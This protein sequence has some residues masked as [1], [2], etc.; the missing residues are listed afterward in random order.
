MYSNGIVQRKFALLDEYLI[1]LQNHLADVDF[2]QFK[3]DW[4]LRCAAERALQVIAEIVIDVTQRTL[5]LANAGPSASAAEALHKAE[6]LNI[7]RD[8][9]L[10][11]PI[12]RFRN[13]VVHEYERIDP[14]VLYDICQNHLERV[15]GFREEIERP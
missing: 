15:R 13:L 7:V 4:V 3:D 10:Y 14:R 11:L 9:S 5:A 6:Q 1:Q 2:E 12:V 8:A